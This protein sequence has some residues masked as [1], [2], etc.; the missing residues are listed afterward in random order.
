MK[1]AG[2]EHSC[3]AIEMGWLGLNGTETLSTHEIVQAAK[4]GQ[5]GSHGRCHCVTG[6]QPQRRLSECVYVCGGV[7]KLVCKCGQ[8]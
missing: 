1:C 5:T 4:W 2:E 6:A 3:R 7:Y 8:Q